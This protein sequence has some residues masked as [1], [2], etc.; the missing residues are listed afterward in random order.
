MRVDDF[1]AMDAEV[2]VHRLAYDDA[3]RFRRNE[4]QQLR[5]WAG[6]LSCLRAALAGWAAAAGWEVLL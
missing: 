1:L 6:T 2:L 3:R 5:A 4:A